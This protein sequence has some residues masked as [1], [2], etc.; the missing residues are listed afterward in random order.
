MKRRCCCPFIGQRGKGRRRGEAVAGARPTDVIGGG[1][2]VVEGGEEAEEA[3]GEW[4]R[5][6]NG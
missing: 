1:D 5:S 2:L 4:R 6:L 3:V